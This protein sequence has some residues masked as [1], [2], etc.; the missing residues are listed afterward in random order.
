MAKT[1]S[2]MQQSMCSSNL[3]PQQLRK[4]R[5]TVGQKEES[6][7]RKNIRISEGNTQESMLVKELGVT[8][9]ALGQAVMPSGN[10]R[11]SIDSNEGDGDVEGISKQ[12]KKNAAGSEG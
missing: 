1:P 3:I 2:S 12:F 8:G 9:D 10:S 5:S 11:L 7:P 6:A 4:R